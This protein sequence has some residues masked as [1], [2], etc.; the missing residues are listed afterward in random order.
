MASRKTGRAEKMFV[1]KPKF[2]L[3]IG[4]CVLFL[5]KAIKVR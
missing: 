1:G 3:K 5:E 2:N 4:K